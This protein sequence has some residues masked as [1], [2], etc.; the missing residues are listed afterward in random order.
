MPTGTLADGIPDDI[1]AE[2][3]TRPAETATPD[4]SLCDE[5]PAKNAWPSSTR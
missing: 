1:R 3:T 5:E 2:R 4:T